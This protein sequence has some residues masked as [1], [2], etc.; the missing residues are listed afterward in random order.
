MLVGAIEAGGTKFVCAVGNESGKVLDKVTF[1]TSD[2]KETLQ[3]VYDFFSSY[4]ISSLGVGSFGPVDLDTTS[5]TYGTILNTP[6]LRWKEFQLLEHLTKHFS[7]P[8]HLD[9]DVNAAALGEY[10]YGA[11]KDVSSCLYI[12]VGTGIGAGFVNN[13]KTYKGKSHP[14]MGHILVQKHVDDDFQGVCPSHGA[15]LEGLASGPAIEK[16][17]GQKGHLLSNRIDVW[18]IEASYLAQAIMNYSLILSPQRVII[19]GGVMKQERLYQLIR[20]A[21]TNLMNNYIDVGD[22]EQFIASPKL[23]DEQGVKGAIALAIEKG[24]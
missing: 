8:V 10:M 19:G 12:T 20:K 4:N 16:R 3:H 1:P 2:P 14:E 6:K 21:F 5:S 15:C 13:G 22:I 24:R 18:E 9:T 23:K 7:I 17:Y 11:G